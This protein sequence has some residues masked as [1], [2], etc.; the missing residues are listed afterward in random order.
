MATHSRI[1]TALG[2]AWLALGV[3]GAQPALAQVYRIVGPDGKVTFTDRAPAD[4]VLAPVGGAVAGAAGGGAGAVAS[5]NL[6]PQLRKAH[7]QYPVMLYTGQDCAPCDQARALL[8]QRGV[9]YTEKTVQSNADIEALKKLSGT[10]GVPFGRIGGQHLQGFSETEW[11]QY[12]DLAGY[13][14]D[15]QLPPSYR[16]PPSSPLVAESPAAPPVVAPTPP[17]PASEPSPADTVPAGPT[18]SNPAGIVF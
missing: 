5:A 3:L 1:S 15:S 8:R 7:S 10:A 16:H 13:P 9:P 14:K 2:A 4:K 6:P 18:P 12:L 11:T 17:S